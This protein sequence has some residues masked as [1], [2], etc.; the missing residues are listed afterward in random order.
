M[1]EVVAELRSKYLETIDLLRQALDENVQLKEHIASLEV[2]VSSVCG[3]LINLCVG[4]SHTFSVS[5]MAT[6]GWWR[7]TDLCSCPYG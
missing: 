3:S 2:E 6:G 7:S 4:T 5:A 1:S